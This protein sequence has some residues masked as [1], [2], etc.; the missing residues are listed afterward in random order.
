MKEKLEFENTIEK[1][2][3]SKVAMKGSAYGFVSLLILK[4]GGLI[5]TII[6]ARILLPELFGIYTLALSIVTL[7]LTF[8]DMGINKTFMRYFSDSLGKRNKKLSRGY[9][10]YLL[11]VKS[12]LIIFV[13]I[14]FIIFSKYISYNIYEKPVQYFLLPYDQLKMKW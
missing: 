13:I 4:F 6:I 8:T 14:L 1:Q 3:L 7:I 12:L 10:K 11:K 5:F 9:F 2:N